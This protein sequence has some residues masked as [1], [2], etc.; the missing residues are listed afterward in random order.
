MCSSDLATSTRADDPGT[1]TGDPYIDDRIHEWT[2]KHARGLTGFGGGA[3]ARA[4]GNGLPF[5]LDDFGT[6]MSSFAYLKY[7]PVDFLKIDRL[8]LHQGQGDRPDGLRDRGLGAIPAAGD[9]QKN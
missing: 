1:S 6:G 5:A 2:G 7:L 8:G 4:E 9:S 3:D